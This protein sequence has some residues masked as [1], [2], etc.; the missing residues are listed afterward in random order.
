MK[1]ITD[2]QECD[3]LQIIN[4]RERERERD[5]LIKNVHI[6]FPRLNM[7]RGDKRTKRKNE[8]KARRMQQV[9]FMY[10]KRDRK[11]KKKN[12]FD[13][14]SSLERSKRVAGRDWGLWLPFGNKN[15]HHHHHR[16]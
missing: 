5:I 4:D 15:N 1:I 11:K 8:R 6:L 10:K 16:N 12:Y 2:D 7:E 9:Y 3:Q 13:R 14:S